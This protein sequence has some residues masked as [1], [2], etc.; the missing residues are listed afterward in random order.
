MLPICFSISLFNKFNN[1]VENAIRPL[2]IGRKNYLFCG[3]NAVA[4]RFAIIYS[5]IGCSKAHR[6][7]SEDMDGRQPLQNTTIRTRKEGLR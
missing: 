2:A 4:V 3:N 7:Q 5:L 1:L 6:G